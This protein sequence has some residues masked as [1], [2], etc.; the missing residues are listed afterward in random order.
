M[1]PSF[2]TNAKLSPRQRLALVLV[3]VVI[4][5]LLITAARLEP[6]ASGYG[7]HKQLGLSD[8]FVLRQWGERCPSCGMTTA[9]SRLLRGDLRGAVA[10][11]AGGVLLAVGAIAAVPWLLASAARGEWCYL[12][13]SASVVLPAVAVLALV[14]LLDWMRHTGL[15][16]LLDH[17]T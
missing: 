17:T 6:D 16:L 1:S 15:T 3:A 14:V 9:W 5:L 13:P 8:C 7:T 4:V 12:R 2:E 10:A 11:N